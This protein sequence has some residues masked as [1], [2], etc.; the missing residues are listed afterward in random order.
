MHSAFLDFPSNTW[1]TRRT[2]TAPCDHSEVADRT[3]HMGAK[4]L[5]LQDH[6]ERDQAVVA[7]PAASSPHKNPL[8]ILNTWEVY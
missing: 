4:N 2:F 3:H 7:S 5:G 6:K 8:L 1:V